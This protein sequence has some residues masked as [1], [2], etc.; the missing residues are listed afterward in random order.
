MDKYEIITRWAQARVVEDMIENMQSAR[1]E[2]RFN[3]N[4][5]IQDTYMALLEK[6]DELIERL[7]LTNQ[8]RFYIARMLV[9]NI[10]SV[11]SPYFKLYKERN[12]E[13]LEN[14]QETE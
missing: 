8:Y 1:R 11:S 13:I 5:L 4:D 2:Q 14:D 6:D 10:I 9:N 7:H 3:L 12:W